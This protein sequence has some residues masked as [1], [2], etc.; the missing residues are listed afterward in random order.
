M[1]PEPMTAA[2]RLAQALRALNE[3]LV[4]GGADGETLDDLAAGAEALRERLAFAT[5][6]GEAI[7]EAGRRLDH[8]SPVTGRSNVAAPPVRIW[9]DGQTVRGAATFGAAF[10]GPPGHVHGGVIAAAFD[11]VLGATQSLAEQAGMTGTLTVRYRRPT[12]LHREVAFAG[13]LE[14][15]SGRKLL[16]SATLHAGEV[17]C[18]EADAIFVAVDFAALE[19]R[20]L[21]QAR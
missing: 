3:L 8:A 1:S 16:A 4:T 5:A 19:A 7:D 17:L 18:A 12:P 13:R 9:I 20:R 21:R 2:E 6:E 10:E 11:E 15:V 14:R